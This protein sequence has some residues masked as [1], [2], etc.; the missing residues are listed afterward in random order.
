MTTS[1]RIIQREDIRRIFY[2]FPD[3]LDMHAAHS[4]P[5]YA[6]FYRGQPFC[7][8][9]VVPQH[10]SGVCGI[11][12]WNTPLVDQHRYIYARWSRRLIERISVV[13]PTIVGGCIPSKTKWLSSLG[14]TFS[15]D[16]FTFKIEAP[17]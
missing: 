12:G 17:Q 10:T 6:G 15:D 1:L 4:N 2:D 9:G 16:L 3:C 8:I 13:Y 14:A 11:W 5:L 7:L